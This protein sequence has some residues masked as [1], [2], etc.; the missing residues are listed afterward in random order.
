MG[1]K[2]FLTCSVAHML[3]LAIF[4]GFE[5]IQLYGIHE[6]I[7][8]EYACEMPSVL[9][10]LGVAYG[11]GIEVT[12]SEDSP[13]LKGYFI[14]GYEDAKKT[15]FQKNIKAEIDRASKI[16]KEAQGNQRFYREEECKCIG[17]ITAFEHIQK[18]TSMI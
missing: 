11:K 6:A 4:E 13:L 16:A 18:L 5:Q 17:A 10:W 2:I 3:A 15:V 1:D 9:Y 12:I 7:D 8:D 14:Y